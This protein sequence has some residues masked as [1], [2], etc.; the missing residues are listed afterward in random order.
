MAAAARGAPHEFDGFVDVERL[1]QVL[2]SAALVSGHRVFQVRMRGNDD[3]R[4][5]RP[6][7]VHF[8][9]KG[10]ATHSRHAHVRDEDVRRLVFHR[11]EQVL[12]ALE[13]ARLHLFLAQGLFQHPADRLV[14]VHDPDVQYVARHV[15]GSD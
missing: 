4:Q 6:A 5:L 14:V 9:E 15:A 12:G 2:E 13:T 11:L 8:F 10:Y 7:P 1:R 3:N